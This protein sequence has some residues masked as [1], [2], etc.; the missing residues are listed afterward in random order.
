MRN[1]VKKTEKVLLHEIEPVAISSNAVPLV[2]SSVLLFA[3]S[4]SEDSLF[5]LQKRERFELASDGED[6]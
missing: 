5:V 1:V 4:G 3:G 2:Q 6:L